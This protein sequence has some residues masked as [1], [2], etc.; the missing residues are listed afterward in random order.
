[1]IVVAFCI[2]TLRTRSAC[3][4]QIEKANKKKYLRVGLH[5]DED[6]DGDE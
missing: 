5:D 1:M 3:E 2:G 4:K 6:E